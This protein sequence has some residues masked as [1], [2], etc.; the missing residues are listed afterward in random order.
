M[1]RQ[2]KG[3][4]RYQVLAREADRKGLRGSERKRYIFG[5]MRGLGWEHPGQRRR[6][7]W[8]HRLF[9][10]LLRARPAEAPRSIYPKS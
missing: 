10:R 9:E 7:S 5:G 3:D 2:G 6:R 8:L 4:W 1:A